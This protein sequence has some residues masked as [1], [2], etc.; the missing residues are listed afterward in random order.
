M[1]STRRIDTAGRVIL[2]VHIRRALNLSEGTLVDVS[3]TDQ[4]EIRIHP[5]AAQCCICGADVEDKPHASITI[6][7]D[8]RHI[9]S[10]CAVRIS[11]GYHD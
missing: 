3:M 2:P 11:E 1:K 8:T 10:E 6:K 4:G 5:A 9:C 7:S